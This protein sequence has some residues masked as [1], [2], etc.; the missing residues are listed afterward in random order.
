MSTSKKSNTAD[1]YEIFSDIEH[2]LN[3]SGMYLGSPQMTVNN[4]H[5]AT[6]DNKIIKKEIN[7]IKKLYIK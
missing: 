2:V 5:I 1:K 4:M 6:D 3:K 7:Y